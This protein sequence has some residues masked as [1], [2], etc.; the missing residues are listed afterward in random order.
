MSSVVVFD[1]GGTAACDAVR[2]SLVTKRTKT[3]DDDELRR[4]GAAIGGGAT[5]S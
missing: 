5:H 1:V 4:R 2:M 3:H